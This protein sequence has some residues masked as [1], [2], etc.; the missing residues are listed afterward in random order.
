MRKWIARVWLGALG[1]FVLSAVF[2]VLYSVFENPEARIIV[3]LLAGAGAT[4]WFT[5]WALDNA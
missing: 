5:G 2:V 4:G 1:L 3:A